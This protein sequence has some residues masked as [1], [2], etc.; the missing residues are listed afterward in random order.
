MST[1]PAPKKKRLSR[2]SEVEFE[3]AK[4]AKRDAAIEARKATNDNVVAIRQ[5]I[6]INVG[7]PIASFVKSK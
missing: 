1:T 7:T 3:A 5:I 2:M 6:S 4:Q